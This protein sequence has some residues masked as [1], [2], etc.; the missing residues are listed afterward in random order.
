MADDKEEEDEEDKVDEFNK[1]EEFD[2]LDVKIDGLLVETEG[3][4]TD[5]VDAGGSANVDAR[6]GAELLFEN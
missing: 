2:E 1:V 6:F 5:G 3:G 4:K